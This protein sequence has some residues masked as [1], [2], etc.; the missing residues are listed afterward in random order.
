MRYCETGPVHLD[1]HR[2][3]NA[4]IG[5]LRT[6]YGYDFL[7]SVFRRMAHDVYRILHE[8]LQRGDPEELIHHWTYFLDREGGGYELQREEKTIRLTV[9]RCPAIAYLQSRGLG[10]DPAFCR[11]TVVVNN[12]LAE[13]TPF[14]II[15]EVLGE[16]RCIQTLRR[17]S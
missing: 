15:T 13:G 7:D 17:R 9:H 12:A 4:T 16:G 1:F 6:Q 3:L 10:V 14:E 8:A 11:Q 5:Y 2:T